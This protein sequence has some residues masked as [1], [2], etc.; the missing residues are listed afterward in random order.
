[1]PAAHPWSDRAT[2]IFSPR[3]HA[4]TALAAGAFL[5]LLFVQVP[6]AANDPTTV[7]ELE[8]ALCGGATVKLVG[9]IPEPTAVLTV[10][11][12]C[13]ATLD[14]NGHTLT[15]HRVVLDTGADLT[16]RDTPA[17]AV[18]QLIAQVAAGRYDAGIQTTGATLRIE[19]G[20][21]SAT[22]GF[23]GAGIGGGFL[24]SGGT[25]TISGGTVTA[26]GGWDGAGIGGGWGG[27]GGTV[28]I[29]G[30]T[31][32]A[33]GGTDGAGIGGG[34][35][36]AG[37]TV[38]ISGGSVKATSGFT[39]DWYGIGPGSGETAGDVTI[40]DGLVRADTEDGGR[41]TTTLTPVPVPLPVPAAVS[42]LVLS[43]VP[44]VPVVGGLVT[45]TVSGGDAGVEIL[46]RA[47]YNPTFAEAGVTLDA[48][49]TGTFSFVVPRAALGEP[50]MVELVEWTAPVSIGVAG[51]PVPGAV[52]AGDGPSSPA[53][54]VVLLLALVGLTVAVVVR[55]V[56]GMTA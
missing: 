47:A 50:L 30:G 26:T 49:G 55:R 23:D 20:T 45:C 27:S 48:G 32:T 4:G 29:S 14:L 56:V 21:V 40:S 33:N 42:G 53:G 5:A 11:G 43:C 39:S 34:T 36:G 2:I 52:P 13:K 12:G 41:R 24:G 37:G 35:G 19:S 44:S 16:I 10:T 46:W 7:A 3:S 31:V 18:G 28:T 38:T 22:G 15:V 6:A 25:I 8:T 17:S 54:R 1:M 9:H 51:G